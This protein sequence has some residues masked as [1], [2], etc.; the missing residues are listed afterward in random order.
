MAILVTHKSQEDLQKRNV[1][2]GHLRVCPVV[3]EEVEEARQ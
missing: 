2:L 1:K 3:K